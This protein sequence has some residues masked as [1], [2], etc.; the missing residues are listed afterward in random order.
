MY[1]LDLFLRNKE[2]E[3]YRCIP[4]ESNNIHLFQLIAKQSDRYWTYFIYVRNQKL[5][6]KYEQRPKNE[7]Y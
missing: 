5:F 2:P 1:I 6:Y 7:R 3:T 4:I